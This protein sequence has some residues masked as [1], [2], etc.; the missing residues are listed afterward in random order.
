MKWK[1]YYEDIEGELHK[2]WTEAPTE[3]DAIEDTKSEYWNCHKI[4]DV[5]PL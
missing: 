2:C 5:I 3:Q 1:V 4:V